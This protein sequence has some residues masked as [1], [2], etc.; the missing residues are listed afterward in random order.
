MKKKV[1]Q[2]KFCIKGFSTQKPL[3]K[4]EENQDAFA[5]N[6]DKG[7][8][9]IS[10]GASSTPRSGLWSRILTQNFIKNENIIKKS[11]TK[12]YSKWLEESRK[13]WEEKA[14]IE[15]L[16]KII[17][18]KLEKSKGSA[19]TFLGCIYSKIKTKNKLKIIYIGD[20]CFF[21]IRNRKIAVAI[22][23]KKSE[24]FDSNPKVLRSLEGG[25]GEKNLKTKNI[26]LKA[27]DTII[28]ATDEVGQWILS[29][30][31]KGEQPWRELENL[32][33]K[34]FEK[35][36]EKIRKNK[37]VDE[38]DMSVIIFKITKKYEKITDYI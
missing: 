22:P 36:I 5:I 27:D 16:P 29:R 24:Q 30:K 26:E 32:T 9:V 35:L 7:I 2:E 17:Q 12:G 31:E 13:E 28:V 19:S 34:K 33:E 14:E 38:D 4:P 1:K 15:K 6:S 11:R 23:F 8:F 10:D 20:S 37:Q 18:I 25:G 3:E 21:L